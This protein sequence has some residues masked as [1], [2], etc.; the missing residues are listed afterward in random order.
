[1]SETKSNERRI[2]T[3]LQARL[4]EAILERDRIPDRLVRLAS[5]DE[6]NAI[7]YAELHGFIKALNFALGVVAADEPEGDDGDG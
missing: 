1:M 5:T 4:N 3:T 6:L 2:I 7:K